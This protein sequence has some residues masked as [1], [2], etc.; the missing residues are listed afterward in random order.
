MSERLILPGRKPTETEL[1]LAEAIG[2]KK[3]KYTYLHWEA[4][5]R[6]MPNMTTFT[7]PPYFS[8]DKR[9][10]PILKQIA[11]EKFNITLEAD[12]D[13]EQVA[14]EFLDKLA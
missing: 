6:D 14:N 5:I 13:P 12:G 11:K 1:K 8:T 2:M 4:L 3:D 10:I 7:Q 9:W